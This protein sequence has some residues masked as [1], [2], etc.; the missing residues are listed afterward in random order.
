MRII[1]NSSCGFN[2][3]ARELKETILKELF[4]LFILCLFLSLHGQNR[5]SADVTLRQLANNKVLR[6][7]KHIAFQSDGKMTVHYLYPYEYFFVTNN[8]GENATYLPSENE[9]MFSNNKEQSPQN[10]MFTLFLSPGYSELN[11]MDEGFVL[12]QLNKE[13]GRIVKTFSASDKTSAGYMF[14]KVVC[15]KDRPIYCD[16]A[17]KDK[18]IMKKIYFT[19]Y[20]SDSWLTFPRCVTQITYNNQGDSVITKEEYKNI[21]TEGCSADTL[22]D[23]TVPVSAKRVSPYNFKQ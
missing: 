12:Q 7:E 16:F 21:C 6:I 2:K 19:D 15:E 14:A 3:T 10:E 5:I 23:F 17:D 9:V 22:F 18:N 20:I 4:P 8:L 11:L 1:R 13:E